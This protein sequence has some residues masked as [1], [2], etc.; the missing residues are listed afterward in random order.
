[1]SIYNRI[2]QQLTPK[3]TKNMDLKTIFFDVYQ[4]LVSIDYDGNE[5][6]WD[7]FSKF[8]NSRGVPIDS[9]QFQKVLSQEKQKYYF[10]VKDPEMK[11]RH[12]NFFDLI[13]AI[14]QNYN[15]EV[16]EKELLDLIWQF[17]QAHH[18]ETKLYP[19][20]KETLHE[21]SLKHTL[22]VAS[23][24]QGSYTQ[25]ELEKLGIAKYFSHFIFSSDIG[26][27]KNNQEF[28]KIC[29]QKTNNQ[30]E[31]CLM[32]GD[33]YLQDVV[34]PKKLGLRAIL[35]RNPLTDG[36]NIID[37]VKPDSTVKLEDIST[38]PLII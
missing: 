15:I 4:T 1:M 14:F 9:A 13:N 8:L 7:I 2:Y 5:K 22:A 29:L 36:E 32:I 12:H 16:D 10:S 35:I 31:E 27:R 18:P 21:L 28:Y 17:R 30:A 3:L 6:A 25:K 11:L 37:D 26:Y 20:V 34:I 38:L 23:Y 33:N 19:G 24:T